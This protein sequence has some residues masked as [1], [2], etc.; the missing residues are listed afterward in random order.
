MIKNEIIGSINPFRDLLPLAMLG[1]LC[2]CFY[3]FPWT[4]PSPGELFLLLLW[5]VP[6]LLP[7]ERLQP[8]L[9]L[10]LG[11]YSVANSPLRAAC[12]CRAVSA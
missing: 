9:A 1:H 7:M 10:Q 2:L 11:M 12:T 5:Q 3:L 6:L 8:R 4:Y